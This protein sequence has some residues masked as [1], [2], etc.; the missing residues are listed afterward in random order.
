MAYKMS[1]LTETYI[2]RLPYSPP[3]KSRAWDSEVKGLCLF[4]GKQSKTWYFQRDVGGK[5]TRKLIGRYPTISADAARQAAMAMALDMTRGAGRIY[6]LSAPTL[7]EAMEVYLARPKLRSDNHKENIRGMFHNH[8]SDWLKLP[9]DEIDRRM[10]VE[11][12]TALHERPTLANSMFKAFRTIWNNARRTS[13]LGE[14]PTISIEWHAERNDNPIIENLSDWTR[15]VDVLENPIHRAFHHLLLFTGFRLNEARTLKW[16]NVHYDRIH[17]PMTKN[18]RSFDFPICEIHREILEPLKS[19][20]REWVFPSPKSANGHVV[21]PAR[22][23]WSA[24]A[25]R[26]TFATVAVESGIMEEVVGRLLNHTSQSVTGSRYVKTS[27]EAMRPA[28]ERA[29]EELSR[30]AELR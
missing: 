27:I 16:V 26:R 20:N 24:H 12:H 28:M 5:T 9:L 11:R 13:N 14:A 8:L 3:G 2:K 30:R 4:I 7:H 18:G 23:D 15:Q 6:Q 25:H 22:I 1:K 10:I 21:S 29:V 19:L 17:L